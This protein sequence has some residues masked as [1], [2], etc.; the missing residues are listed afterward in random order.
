MENSA[1][2]LIFLED[3]KICIFLFEA[4]FKSLPIIHMALTNKTRVN[5]NWHDYGGEQFC[6]R[7]YPKISLE[8]NSV[9]IVCYA[10]I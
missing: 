2:E 9:R 3:I 6:S 5:V 8:V 1:K 7:Y 4:T 10:C